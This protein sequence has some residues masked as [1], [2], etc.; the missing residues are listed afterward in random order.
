MIDNFMS[1]MQ[2]S[3]FFSMLGFTIG[4]SNYTIS[5]KLLEKIGFWDTCKYSKCE[6]G[7]I[8]CKAFWK[9]CGKTETVQIY[10]PFNQLNLITGKGYWADFVARVTQAR[11]HSEDQI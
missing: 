3:Q 2:C 11:R 1:Y 9:T 5:Y 4:V 6:D 10:I 8:P 7:R